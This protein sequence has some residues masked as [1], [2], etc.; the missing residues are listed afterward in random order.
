MKSKQLKS[1]LKIIVSNDKIFL[2]CSNL[3]FEDVKELYGYIV[4]SRTSATKKKTSAENG[5]KGGRPKGVSKKMTWN[6]NDL[7][8]KR[9]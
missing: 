1:G 8:Q 2:P 4:G 3:D 9:K 7:E 6:K 5:K